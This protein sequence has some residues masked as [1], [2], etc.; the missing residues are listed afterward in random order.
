MRSGMRFVAASGPA[1]RVEW[2]EESGLATLL[3]G[4][5]QVRMCPTALR[6]LTRTLIDATCVMTQ[7]EARSDVVRNVAAPRDVDTLH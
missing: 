6:Q 1:G 7:L 3:V 2:S 4:D 5:V